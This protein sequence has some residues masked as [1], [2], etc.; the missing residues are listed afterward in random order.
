MMQ[1]FSEAELNEV[2]DDIDP[3]YVQS[4]VTFWRFEPTPSLG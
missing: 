1:F 4:P 2:A 3:P